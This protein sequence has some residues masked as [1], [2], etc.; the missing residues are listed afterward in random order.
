[1]DWYKTR[2]SSEFHRNKRM[3]VWNRRR[4]SRLGAFAYFKLHVGRR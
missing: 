3:I 2:W 4:I 1:M